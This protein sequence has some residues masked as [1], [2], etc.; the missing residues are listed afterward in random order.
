MTSF[1]TPP[2]VD[3]SRDA[4]SAPLTQPPYTKGGQLN[5]DGSTTRIFIP[6]AP[7]TTTPQTTTTTTTTD[8][9]E[10]EVE[11]LEEEVGGGEGSPL[12]AGAGKGRRTDDG[13]GVDA[14]SGGG[15]GDDADTPLVTGD[16]EEGGGQE[17][18]AAG[19]SLPPVPRP[20]PPINP[21]DGRTNHTTA[22]AFIPV[23]LRA[24]P[25]SPPPPTLHTHTNT[26][27]HL[28]PSPP[29][30]LSTSLTPI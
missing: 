21:V 11:E 8:N 17:V 2:Q 25:V 12:D 29:I 22:Y 20:A 28:P 10:E 14:G 27:T 19:T 23:T 9:T 4:L 15:V 13:S 24:D 30:P 1:I 7:P 16:E 18:A 5:D 3:A 26:Y 6:Y